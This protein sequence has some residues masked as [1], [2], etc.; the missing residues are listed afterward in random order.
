MNDAIFLF[1]YCI[2]SYLFNYSSQVLL[3]FLEIF[4]SNIKDHDI[5]LW[6]VQSM[7]NVEIQCTCIQSRLE[8]FIWL[9][10]FKQ[11]QY[12]FFWKFFSISHTNF[13]YIYCRRNIACIQY[14]KYFFKL[15]KLYTIYN[16][17]RYSI[18]LWRMKLIKGFSQKKHRNSTR[19]HF[20]IIRFS[21]NYF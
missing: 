17:V 20:K 8:I 11:K 15:T 1:W 21:R 5:F 4:P 2:E 19:L 6:G 13:L 9:S 16:L 12:F 10:I 14:T 7:F 18:T 3:F